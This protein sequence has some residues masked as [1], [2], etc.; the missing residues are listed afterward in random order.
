MNTL[1]N[2]N[3]DV[4]IVRKT[5]PSV[6]EVEAFCDETGPGPVLKSMRLCF[7]VPLS[8]AWNNDLAEQFVDHF[9]RCNEL[10]EG[11]KPLVFELFD[12]RFHCLKRRYNEW[13]IKQGEDDVQRAQRV[14]EKQKL[15][16]K[17]QR[18]DTRRNRV[19]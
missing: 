11:E 14:K 4:D 6:E 1:L 2:I 9:M 3:Q 5:P 12:M 13:R 7:D 16:R 10:D 8:N 17:V 15:E 19:S 18:R